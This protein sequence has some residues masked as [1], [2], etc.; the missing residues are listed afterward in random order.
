MKTW[1]KTLA[2]TTALLPVSL[3]QAATIIHAGQAFT[4]TSE[5]LTGPI[6][7]VVDG[8]TIPGLKKG[9]SQ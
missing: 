6:S 2:L 9:I 4:S 5:K 1:L 8:N 7:I 3:V